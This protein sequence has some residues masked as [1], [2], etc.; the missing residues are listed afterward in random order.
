MPASRRSSRRL[1]RQ[2][3]RSP[4]CWRDWTGTGAAKPESPGTKALIWLNAL[5]FQELLAS[6][7]DMSLLPAE[8]RQKTISR[9][10]PAGIHR[11]PCCGSGKISLA[12]NWWPIFHVARETLRA[13]PGSPA[14]PFGHRSC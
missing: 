3:I 8:H 6:H 13:T 2:S 1:R 12:I 9:P 10:D 14:N 7:L 4:R 11:R 5:V